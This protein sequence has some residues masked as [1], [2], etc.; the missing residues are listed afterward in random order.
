MGTN[1]QLVDIEASDII[2]EIDASTNYYFDVDSNGNLI[3]VTGTTAKGPSELLAQYTTIECF[4]II[5]SI[6]IEK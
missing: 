6:D 4:R 3:E 2:V 1:G 5:N